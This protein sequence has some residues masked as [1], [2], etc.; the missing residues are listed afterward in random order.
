M[1]AALFLASFGFTKRL[2]VNMPPRHG[3]S[4]L[5]S[6][7]FPLWYLNTF[8]DRRVMVG[9]FAATIGAEF[10]RRTRNAATEY[11]RNL[12]IRR[13]K[14]AGSKYAWQTTAGGWMYGTGVGG[15]MTSRGADLMLVDDPIKDAKEAKSETIRQN[16]WDWYLSTCRSRLEPSGAIV[17]IQTRWHED[18]LA[19]R[20]LQASRDGTGEHWDVLSFPAIA[21][22][23]EAPSLFGYQPFTRR[24]GD[25]LWPS[26]WPREAL[27]ELVKGVGG[28]DGWVWSALYQQR[29]S[30]RD[31]G[32]FTQAMFSHRYT[33]LPR[34][35]DRSPVGSGILR[36]IQ[37]IDTSYG[38]GVGSDFSVIATAGMDLTDVYALDQWRGQVEFPELRRV[39]LEQAERHR[40]DRI[41]IEDTGAGRS[42]L[43]ALRRDTRLP[44]KRVKPIGSKISRAESTTVAWAGG[45]VKLPA[46]APWVKQMI[47][48]HM[49]FPNAAHDDTVDAWAYAIREL[50]F[51]GRAHSVDAPE[52][53]T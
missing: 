8:P 12:R 51:K 37:A 16:V 28:F 7:W 1:S 9:S 50:L 20:L 40:P 49:A 42:L 31:G 46:S 22:T 26:R 38:E 41:L 36:K 30:M 48:E 53:W 43:Q 39:V 13:T 11:S 23:D 14:D 52:G 32:I 3:K 15:I 29:P 24:K 21:E 47:A 4:E 19:G 33:E 27:L 6:F 5:C 2:I 17:V 34:L 44:L 25:A 45:K 35:T 10:S 18:D